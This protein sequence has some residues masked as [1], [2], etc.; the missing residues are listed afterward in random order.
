MLIEILHIVGLTD[1]W[2][3]GKLQEELMGKLASFFAIKKRKN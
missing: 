2:N 3:A 1:V